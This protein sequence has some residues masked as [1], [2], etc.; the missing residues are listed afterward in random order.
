M[1]ELVL[2]TV[3][4][5]RDGDG[6]V[7]THRAHKFSVTVGVRQLDSWAVRQLRADLTPYPRSD[8]PEKSAAP[9]EAAS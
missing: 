8:E 4:L 1:S 2:P 3:T 6:V 7:I 5:R 9:S